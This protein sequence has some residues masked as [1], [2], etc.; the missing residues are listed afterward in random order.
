MRH[1][2]DDLASAVKR[3]GTPT[4]VGLDPRWEQLPVCFTNGNTDDGSVRAAAYEKFC[5]EIIDVVAPLVPAVKPQ[6]AFFEECGPAGMVALGKVIAYAREKG[7]LSSS[8]E[9]ATT[10]ARLPKP[11]PEAIWAATAKVPGRP[12]PSRSAPTLVPTVCSLLST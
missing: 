1:F 2:G 4:L 9:N 12:M 7:C 11:T 10:L 6:A 3:T 5:C 8:T